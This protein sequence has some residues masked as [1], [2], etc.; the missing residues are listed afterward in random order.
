[1]HACRNLLAA[2]GIV[3]LACAH[4]AHAE[5]APDLVDLKAKA[6]AFRD[7]PEKADALAELAK[8]LW[9]TDPDAA[10]RYGEQGL[11]L[12]E[13]LN[14][15]RG[16]AANLNAVGV[17][18]YLRGDNERALPL[19]ERS[20]ALHRTTGNVNSAG[21]VA[22]NIGHLHAAASRHA[23]A[24]AAYEQA[25]Q[26]SAQAGDDAGVATAKD[27]VGNL[28]QA[29]GRFREAIAAYEDAL[30]WAEKAGDAQSRAITLNNLAN[31]QSE[32]GDGAAALKGYLAAA[33]AFERL[34][35]PLYQALAYSNVA[36]ILMAQGMS[37][38]ARTWLE[39]ALAIQ[40][41]A[42]SRP[43]EANTL[44]NLGTLLNDTGKTP[45]AI[46]AYEAARG[47]Y[48]DVGDRKG[49]AIA[50]H[51]LGRS[52]TEQKRFEDAIAFLTQARELRT[53]IEDARGAVS[54]RISLGE[55]LTAAGRAAEAIP[56]LEAALAEARTLGVPELESA[57]RLQLALAT[58]AAGRPAAAYD[59]LQ[60]HV[61]LQ[62]RLQ[63]ATAQARVAE[64]QARFESEKSARE[65]EVL[66]RD[67]E[68]QALTAKRQQTLRNALVVLAVLL[69]LLAA[70]MVSRYRLKRKSEAALQEKNRLLE[71]AHG[72]VAAERDRSEQLLLNVLPPAIAGRLKDRE[73]TIAD[74]FSEATIL[75][76]D[77][78]G[79]TVLS[80]R[81]DAESVVRVLND[82]FTRFDALTDKHGL[83]KIKTIGDCYMV[84]GG[85][86]ASRPD[87]CAAV[88][89]MA[90]DMIRA[91]DAFNAETGQALQIRI[92]INTGAV[93][94]GVIGRKKFIYDLW[95]DAVN[96]ASR[97]ESHGEPSRIHATDAVVAAIG[98]RYRF[99]ER[100]EI[101]VKGK[102]RMRTWFLL[103]PK[104]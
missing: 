92:G 58:R 93:V 104:G 53:A 94:A 29:Q 75:F 86:P 27:G 50:L 51:N 69:A 74:R 14:H 91:L 9:Q 63:G 62:D 43:A 55:T 35:L 32:A 97:M 13:R 99:D 34:D 90:L 12:S 26:L 54:S 83:E 76:A 87:H 31:T 46:V 85:V 61:E 23:E 15:D 102:G 79:F 39:R 84:V 98:D 4:V 52:A 80:Q 2:A 72:E 81:M 30:R 33:E 95:G 6:E 73:T 7:T 41:K 3:M 100:G 11:A 64:M 77:I 24:L 37:D 28:L 59:H 16:R 25:A 36:P 45:E 96:T 71:I 47:I 19:L 8:A 40:R 10:L 57:A 1:M 66:Q 21:R 5:K 78:V 67:R 65:I 60:A 101:E 44:L 48:R 22:A 18:H 20:L 70:V 103:G 88:A 56:L 38:Q 89:D 68:I 49:E 42:G 17:V 82:V